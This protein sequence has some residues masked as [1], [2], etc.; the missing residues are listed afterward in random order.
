LAEQREEENL[1]QTW[2]RRLEMAG[3][4]KAALL[5]LDRE[6]EAYASTDED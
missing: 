1:M 5:L 3:D 2:T 4:N 6:A